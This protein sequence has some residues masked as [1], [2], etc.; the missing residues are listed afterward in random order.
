LTEKDPAN[1]MNMMSS[2]VQKLGLKDFVKENSIDIM[3]LR[4]LAFKSIKFLEVQGKTHTQL[5][6]TS[7]KTMKYCYLIRVIC[8]VRFCKQIYL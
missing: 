3:P 2:S 5:Q 7:N 8:W 4:S 6:F 1:C